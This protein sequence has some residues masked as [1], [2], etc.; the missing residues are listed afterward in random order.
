MEARSWSRIALFLAFLT[1]FSLSADG[2][3]DRKRLVLSVRLQ[4]PF[5]RD[6]EIRKHIKLGTPFFTKKTNGRVKNTISGVVFQ[7]QEGKYELSLT[8]SEWASEKDNVEDTMALELELNKPWK[9]GPVAS[10]VYGRT[11]TLVPERH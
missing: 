3:T 10:F 6:L 7:E 11:V 8:I 4:D 1:P 9:G 5:N 2:R